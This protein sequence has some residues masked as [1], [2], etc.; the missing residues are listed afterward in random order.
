M[1]GSASGM[2]FGRL[3]FLRFDA[4]VDCLIKWVHLAL[5]FDQSPALK[6]PCL[7]ARTQLTYFLSFL[8]IS[9]FPLYLAMSRIF[10]SP[11]VQ[12]AKGGVNNQR[13]TLV[14]LVYSYS[15]SIWTH[16]YLFTE[17]SLNISCANGNLI[18][19]LRSVSNGIIKDHDSVPFHPGKKRSCA[20][21]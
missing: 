12:N 13:V 6:H 17:L 8:T 5:A 1:V 3:L 16:I 9:V 7:R 20:S 2:F 15:I 18:P 11:S 10:I 21:R 14:T 4:V 19:Y